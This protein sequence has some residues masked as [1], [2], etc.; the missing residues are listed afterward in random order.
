MIC[1]VEDNH[2]YVYLCICCFVS[3]FLFVF[4]LG[5]KKNRGEDI[6]SR[7]QTRFADLGE[8]HQPAPVFPH[9]DAVDLSSSIHY[10]LF[11]SLAVLV[12]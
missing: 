10:L 2:T 3:P 7:N 9:D 1:V 5:G 8:L 6:N 12:Y 4:M 11:L